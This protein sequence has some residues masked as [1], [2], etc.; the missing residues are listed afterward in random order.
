MRGISKKVKFQL[1]NR[2]ILLEKPHLALLSREKPT[3]Q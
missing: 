3:Y 1:G 2:N